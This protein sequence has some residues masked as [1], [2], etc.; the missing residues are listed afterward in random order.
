MPKSALVEF[1]NGL[2]VALEA[3]EADPG[4]PE[5]GRSL[6]NL[7]HSK[8]MACEQLE[9]YDVAI[10]CCRREIEVC[11]S[12]LRGRPSPA[13]PAATEANL[14][15][16]VFARL[17]SFLHQ[18]RIVPLVLQHSD[19]GVPVATDG[20]DSIDALLVSLLTS[21]A[22]VQHIEPLV[23]VATSDL[24]SDSIDARHLAGLYRR[25]GEI[26]LKDGR[27]AQA[28]QSFARFLALSTLLPEGAIRATGN[29]ASSNHNG[30]PPKN[31]PAVTPPME[32]PD[33]ETE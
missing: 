27:L 32:E 28:H 18:L 11:L 14:D 25:L 6:M 24:R 22:V 10:D 15:P 19:D 12:V 5:L 16:D 1:D 7:Y 23:V 4:D 3:W 8:A 26:E 9:L 2:K 17:R 20:I 30:V 21:S 33:A 13:L 29:E 31:D